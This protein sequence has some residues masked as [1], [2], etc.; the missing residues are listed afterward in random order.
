M[1]YKHE[2]EQLK[3]L[4][5]RKSKEDFQKYINNLPEFFVEYQS[6]YSE[7]KTLVRQLLPDRLNDFASHYEIQKSRRDITP[8]NYRIFDYLSNICVTRGSETIVGPDAAINHFLQQMAIV[9]SI[10]KRFESSL[11]DIVQI[12]QADLFDSELD[13]A[14]ALVKRGFLRAGGAVA[15]VVLEK[16]LAQVCKNHKITIRKKNPTISD[17]NEKLKKEGVIDIPQWRFN[18][19]LGDIRNLCT[20][21]KDDEPT[22]GDVEELINGVDKVTKTLF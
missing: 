15:G 12:A 17:F 18:Q 8:S 1:L 3:K 2:K 14:S 21:N 9:R 11:F 13:S 16:H 19:R 4:V 20:H 10:Q 5:K 7:A 22:K 6:W